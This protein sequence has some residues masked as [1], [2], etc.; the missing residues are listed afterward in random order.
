MLL[1]TRYSTFRQAQCY[2][3]PS[4]TFDRA[5]QSLIA[6]LLSSLAVLEHREG[7][8]LSASTS[9]I[10]AAQKLGGP[11]TGFVAGSE[12]RSVAEEA[13]K[14]QGLEKIIVVENAAYDKVRLFCRTLL[15]LSMITSNHYSGSPGELRSFTR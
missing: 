9:A 14:V 11:I 8:I 13:A 3:R 10:T 6:R 1:A 15:R 5:R 4:K 2:F 12:V 7:K